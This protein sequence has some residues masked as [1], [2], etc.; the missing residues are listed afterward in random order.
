[1][2]NETEN[3]KVWPQGPSHSPPPSRRPC[4]R[5]SRLRAS[6]RCRC[7]GAVWRTPC[8]GLFRWHAFRAQRLH[9]SASFGS[10]HMT[11]RLPPADPDGHGCTPSTAASAR[12]DS[13]PRIPWTHCFR[14]SVPCAPAWFVAS[15]PR[16]RVRR[17]PAPGQDPG[18]SRWHSLPAVTAHG[19]S[20]ASQAA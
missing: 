1:M 18:L 2:K 13:R 14:R 15:L 7:G 12:C 3:N 19:R 16:S 4:G 20:R 8:P 5:R 10:V 9:V 17:R 6:I 11:R